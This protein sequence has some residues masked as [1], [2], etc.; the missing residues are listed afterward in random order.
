MILSTLGPSH[1]DEYQIGATKVSN[2]TPND[3]FSWFFFFGSPICYI[4][5]LLMHLFCD[6][7]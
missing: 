6:L 1:K 3:L 2:V 4:M 5:Y 7:L